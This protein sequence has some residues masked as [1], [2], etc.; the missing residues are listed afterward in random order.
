MAVTGK[1]QSG[2]IV[3]VLPK[4]P[5][6]HQQLGEHP[7]IVLTPQAEIDAGAVLKVVVCSTTFSYPLPP[8][9]FDMP[10]DPQGK[11]PTG[12]REACVAKATFPDDIPQNDVKRIAGRAPAAL[13]RQIQ[14]WLRD[15][16]RDADRKKRELSGEESSA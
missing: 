6:T 7:A 11:N 10:T 12:L 4:D 14:Q 9:W 8:G 15:K 16:K 13:V 5:I 2:S 3:W 1:I